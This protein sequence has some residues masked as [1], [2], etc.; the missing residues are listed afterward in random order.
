MWPRTG[1]PLPEGANVG[2]AHRWIDPGAPSRGGSMR[3]HTVRLLRALTVI[4]LASAPVSVGAAVIYDN[5][6]PD[7]GVAFFS[8]PS[9]SGQFQVADNFLLPPA[10]TT[11]TDV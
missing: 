1:R 6:G 5:G 8:D 9:T 2:Y 10:S 4:L 11:I 7:G 3:Y